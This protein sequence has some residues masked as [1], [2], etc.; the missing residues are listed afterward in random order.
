MVAEEVR[1]I[2]VTMI[3]KMLSLCK[4]AFRPHMSTASDALGKVLLDKFPDVKR[5]AAE[6]VR[7]FC[8]QMPE[9]IGLNARQI[10][11]SLAKNTEHNHSKI[12][13]VSVEVILG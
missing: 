11:K 13:K 9:Q 1:L 5:Q 8:A 4:D 3:G 12:R 2:V 7:L 10:I 6:T